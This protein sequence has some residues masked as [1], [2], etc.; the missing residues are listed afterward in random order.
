MQKTGSKLMIFDRQ[1]IEERTYWVERLSKE[2]DS[3]NLWLDYPRRQIVS[4]DDNEGIGFSI[5]GAVHEKL[6]KLTGD[7][8]FLIYTTV[9][10]GLK[11]CLHKYTGN[12]SIVVGSP[13]KTGKQISDEANALAIVDEV[14][15][16]LTFR[17][18][19]LNLSQT[20]KAAYQRQHYPYDRLLRD[21][22][23]D[24]VE[25]K[26]P[27]FDIALVL[28]EFHG[29]MPNKTKH[30][31]TIILNRKKGQ[32]SAWVEFNKR[33]F[34]RETI[35]RF[36]SHLLHVLQQGLEDT[37]RQISD[38]Q[39]L[40]EA[41]RYQLLVQWNRTQTDYPRHACIHHLFEAQVEET[42]D[43]IAVEFKNRFL[44]Y[45]ELNNLANQLA[46]Y[47]HEL[48]VGPEVLVGICME[49]SLDMMVGLLGVLKA[50]GAYVPM[51]PTYPRDRLAFMMQ[52]A[53]VQV[54][55]T[56]K[57]LTMSLPETQARL[58]CLDE[59][60]IHKR[61]RFSLEN[62]Q[63]GVHPDNMAYVIYTSGST[64]KPKGA[65]IVHRGVVN[66]L[67]WCTKAYDVANGHG[68]PVQS[69][70]SFDATITSLFSPLM[71]G[72]K[73]L[74][75]P[76]EQEIEE[77][78]FAL[79]SQSN[80]SLI[81]I[82]PAHLTVLNQLLS[83][84]EVAGRTRALIIGGEALGAKTLSFWQNHDPKTRLINEYGPTETVVGCCVYEVLPEQPLSGSV[85]IG[86]PI[87][88]TQLYILD[89]Y[90]YPVPIGVAG[91]LY[92]GG[93]GVARGYL[94]RPQLTA[95]RFIPNPFKAVFPNDHMADRLYKTGDLARY[96]PDGNIEFLGRMDNQIKIRGYRIELGEIDSIL[97]QHNHVREALVMVRE[98]QPGDKRLVAYIVPD[99]ELEE[100]ELMGHLRDKLPDYMIP[101]A[102]VRLDAL[103]LTPNGKVD[104]SALPFPDKGYTQKQYVQPRTPTEEI[105]V[106]IWV[107]ILNY[108]QIGIYDNFFELGGHSL[109]ATQLL[110]RV[111]DTFEVD[112]PLRQVFQSPTIA[113]LGEQI[114]TVIR[115]D[116]PTPI[117]PVSRDGELPLSF[118]Q[119]RLWFLNQ[120]EPD[121]PFYNVY[122]ALQLKGSLHVKALEQSINEIVQRHEVLRT[123]FP[124]KDGKAFQVIAPSLTIPLP[125]IDLKHLSE[126]EQS[127]EVKRLAVQEARVPF[128]LA[129]GPLVRVTLLELVQDKHV[130]LFT[131]HHI[132]SDGWSMGIVINELSVLYKALV[133]NAV[134][135]LPKPSIQYT[136]FALWQRKWF[137]GEVLEKQLAYW[138]EHLQGAS[139]ELKLPTD[140]PRPVVQSYRGSSKKFTIPKEV[141]QKLNGLSQKSGS[142]LF[143]TLLAAFA[144]LLSRYSD[145]KDMVIGSPIANRNR[146][147]IEPLIGFFV[148]TLALR[149]DLNGNPTFAELLDR[150]RRVAL[151]AYTHQDLPF[152]KLVDELQ[153]E[154][155]LS[156]NPLFQVMLALQNAPIKTLNLPDLDITILE[157]DRVSAQF[158][159][160]L[161]VWEI[162]DELVAVLEYNTDLFDEGTIVRITNHFRTLLAG[163]DSETPISELHI[164]T[165][166]EEEELLETLRGPIRNHYPLD[167]GL[168]QLFQE[169]VD[170]APQRIALVHGNKEITYKDLNEQANQIAHFLHQRGVKKNDFVGILDERG[171]DFLG[172]M[173]GILKEGAA[174]LP[175]DPH[176][177]E[178]RIGYM[179]EDSQIRV[180]ITRSSLLEKISL[181]RGSLPPGHLRHILCL[182]S[183]ARYH[184]GWD[185]VILY[186]LS[187]LMDKPKTNPELVYDQDDQLLAY[188]LYTSGS[189]GQPKGAI[190]HHKGAVNH[191]YA[192]FE[193]LAFHRDTAFL[194]SAPSSS[195]ISVWQFLGP[196]LIGGRTVIADYETVCDPG[197]LFKVI[198][199]ANVTLIELVP[200][201]LKALLDYAAQLPSEARV[202]PALEWAMVTGEAVSVGLVNQW[203]TTYP[204]IKLVNAY[205]PTEASDDICQHVMDTP[206]PSEKLSVPI[207]KPLANLTIYVLDRNL[208][209]VPLGVPGEICVS[210]VGVGKGYWHKKDKSGASFAANPYVQSDRGTVLYRTGDLGRWL[211]D[212]TLEFLGRLDHQVQIRGFRIELGEI[213]AIL[214]QHPDVRETVV[215]VSEDQGDDRRLIAYVVPTQGTDRHGA[216]LH[217]NADFETDQVDLWQSLHEKSYSEQSKHNNL[218]FNTI[219][220]DSTYTGLPLS[221]EE[222]HECIHNAV[223]R[224]LSLKPESILEIGCGTGL[225]L[226]RLIPYCQRYWGTDLSLRALEQIEKARGLIT[227]MEKV[228]LFHKRADDFD[229]IEAES[230]DVVVL[231]SVIQ[232]FPS[233]DYLLRVLES[234]VRVVKPGG[235]IFIGDVRSLPLLR[236]YY[237]SVQLYK[238]SPSLS[239]GELNERIQQQMAQEQELA[240]EPA[241][242]LA[243]KKRFPQI[244]YVRVQPKRGLIHNEM[245]RFRY[246]V[247]ISIAKD[248]HAAIEIEWMNWQEDQPDVSDICQHLEKVK[249]ALWG[250]RS[251]ANSRMTREI[252]ALQWLATPPDSQSIEAIL[253][254]KSEEETATKGIDPEA[255]WRLSQQLP[256][257]VYIRCSEATDNG[258][259][260]VVFCHRFN[261]N[262]VT[263][264]SIDFFNT[265][266]ALRPWKDYANNPLHERLVQRLIPTLRD[267]V[268]DR[269]PGHMVPSDFV[270]LEAMPLLPNGK[271]DRQALPV[272]EHSMLS[273]SY[274][275]PRTQ[276]EETLCQIWAHVLGRNQV[277]IR[278]NFFEIGGHSLKATQVASQ[279]H[280][281][282]A[283][284]IPLRSIF[285]HPTIEGLAKEIAS[286]KSTA[287][288][289]IEKIPD[290]PHYPLSHAQR[291]LWV[292]SQMDE[293]SAAYH[294]P[295]AL[296][297]EGKVD[298]EAFEEVL[299]MLIHRHEALRTT[300][301]TVDAEPRQKVH[302]HIDFRIS[303]VDL[304]QEE[305]DPEACAQKLA[306]EDAKNLFNLEQGPL[307]RLSLLKLGPTR[308]VLLFN[309]HHII[310][311][312]WS[313]DVLVREFVQLYKAIHQG[314]K[315]SL[316]APLSIQYRDYAIWQNNLLTGDSVAQSQRYWHNKLS[317]HIPVLNLPTD[318]PRPSVKTFNGKKLLFIMDKEQTQTLLTFSLQHRVS[319]F[320]TLV[321]HVKVLLYRY[322]GQKDIIVGFPMAGRNHPDLEGQIGFY[323]NTLALRS[324]IETG[325]SFESLL[326]QIKITATE[327]YE[328]QSYP[329]DRLVDELLVDRDVSRSPLFDVM[330]V[331][332]N[333]QGHELSLDDLQITPFAVEYQTSQFDL[334]FGFEERPEGLYVTLWYNTDLFEEGRIRQMY[335]HFQTLMASV[336]AN[337]KTAVEQ[338]TILPQTERKQL[339]EIFNNPQ[340]TYPKPYL[341]KGTTLVDLFEEQAAQKSNAVAVVFEDKTL[342]YGQLNARANQ[343]AHYLRKIHGI[344]PDNLI[345][346][347][348]DRTE[349]MVTT[350]LGVLKAGG[351]YVPIDPT[352]PDERIGFIL[353]D[354]GCHVVLTESQYVKRIQHSAPGVSIA[355]MDQMDWEGDLPNPAVSIPKDSAAYVI[356]TSGST[357]KPKGCVVTHHNVVHL[358]KNARLNFDFGPQ[359]VWVIAHSFCFDFSVW[360]MYGALLYGARVIVAKQDMVRNTEAFHHLIH[361]HCVTVLNQTPAAFYN[362]IEVEAQKAVHEL[363]THLR[364]VI[365]GGDR[366]E[367]SYLRPWL[368]WYPLEQI[369]LVNMYGITETTVHVTYGPI[370]EEDVYSAEGRSPIGMPLPGVQVYICD[371]FLNLQP[372]GVP[373][374]L[375]V[376][377]TGVCRG[378]LNRP[379]L[380]EQRFILSPFEKGQRLYRSGDLGRW[381]Q[382]DGTLEHLGRNDNQVQIRG[383]RIELGEIEMALLTHPTVKKS[384]VIAS[385]EEPTNTRL[386]AYVVFNQGTDDTSELRQHLKETLPDYMIPAAFVKLSEIPLTPNG[387]ID[388]QA[389]PAPDSIR[390]EQRPTYAPPQNE[391][392]A[393][394]ASLWKEALHVDKVGIYDNFFDL[395][396][397]SLIILRIHKK[398]Q[399]TFHMNIP[400]VELFRLPT[401]KALSQFINQDHKEQQQSPSG[402][403]EEIQNRAKKQIEARKQRKRQRNKVSGNG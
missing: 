101:S 349:Q 130:M 376:G 365:F 243:L 348:L 360:E 71:V 211:S 147:E 70:I 306:I 47:L 339:V 13:A 144:T 36:I 390:D 63:N 236:A 330:V 9:M 394:I 285:S 143:M 385:H 344:K 40:S 74:L 389:L 335:G 43:A 163:I 171:A 333:V 170:S 182:D 328:H 322:T 57:K 61:D 383:F 386:V 378:Y 31:I 219:G 370:S 138:K 261:T 334:T 100:H 12:T 188:L 106:G 403:S 189:T 307:V 251:V 326:E 102:F 28:D 224:I 38:L 391:V 37:T 62:P 82:T 273:E 185:S 29:P 298:P 276:L 343:V 331:L 54:L 239:K 286:K 393:I 305:A 398:L 361:K 355:D 15:P 165:K 215:I 206:L 2:R 204:T 201:V 380:T 5:S 351:A 190:I 337:P 287:Y 22:G 153:I 289:A 119:E 139:P 279:I 21:L 140:R 302:D 81:K 262:T 346:V 320:M 241:F 338:L 336:L 313:M 120:L 340:A 387:K 88:N 325:I 214:A 16:N 382:E 203:L 30:D 104:C 84:H 117:E 235:A 395:G 137:Q 64:G 103:P 141:T 155:D 297:L 79:R 41:E 388:R 269:L 3:S 231:N 252:R 318:F 213:E 157:M 89:R 48:G 122:V 181:D 121:N 223:E 198:R 315:P 154:R 158:D 18:F 59:E 352:Y 242:F 20:L 110:S 60:W 258:A 87:A 392:Q 296:L 228:T 196:I 274:D 232:Y 33:L 308:H 83:V 372:I 80:L 161:D 1:M 267:F 65:M 253:L 270:V 180:L 295:E 55:L 216:D 125:M 363:N 51:D 277:G 77:L 4:Y 379:E 321:S 115:K 375:Y 230:F 244:H 301:I 17:Q 56:Q 194:Q 186:D 323:V 175:I 34:K 91:E 45:R 265:E 237:A 174:F 260:D 220:W 367:P 111:R 156:R 283:V 210:G 268:K 280:K 199:S 396:G 226:F 304:T 212:G 263:E 358:I 290:A 151:D 233:V 264:D 225:V 345:A 311:D 205:G 347:F 114:D 369:K 68:A 282:L 281:E 99:Q 78:S 172:A 129:K 167:K 7:S 191:I 401:I 314:E 149:I 254:E 278:N 42:P 95:E 271:V 76:D 255:I 23:L 342:T 329:F 300:F 10:A 234:A 72:K 209:L 246:D 356:Y 353:A 145:D 177:P 173:L 58:V 132:V 184:H 166:E 384:I 257:D 259:F 245:T 193:A 312:G 39:I 93:E 67:S 397:H 291:R 25:H 148:N 359:D 371:D 134:A 159:L 162:H 362:L 402:L 136:D 377:G 249:P 164:L 150:V 169:Q 85:P 202:L 327:A 126:P 240:I 324:H 92:I 310:S 112:L 113:G 178:E 200:A 8:L 192:Q 238:A 123:T 6:I 94:N 176:Y 317:G 368:Q 109:L 266:P 381:R 218:T 19:L 366:L 374:E 66:Y 316:L 69:S 49:R 124:Q 364:Y 116:R 107:E 152:E 105:L 319:L 332:Q 293:G 292:L 131:M 90:L 227:G 350:L 256:Y 26:C 248:R 27:V 179:I 288:R 195:D 133:K 284:E 128:D 35:E 75:L 275:K 97:A 303:F 183:E 142:T 46:H 160:V 341:I 400:V 14:E 98:D 229:G 11:V 272:P 146:T 118:A 309:M 197:Q 187:H 135:A 208:K 52:D 24:Q 50:G 32:I 108:E 44:T 127:Y 96:L 222:M 86:R 354:S 168:H 250:L 399:E 299:Q 207:G 294:M 73:V 221:D 357:G 373:G 53:Q 217:F 247:T